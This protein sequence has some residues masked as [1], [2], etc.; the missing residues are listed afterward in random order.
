[1]QE[2][3]PPSDRKSVLRVE[4]ETVGGMASPEAVVE[5]EQRGAVARMQIPAMVDLTEATEGTV[6]FSI[7]M[8]KGICLPMEVLDS[9]ALQEH[10]ANRLEPYTLEE[11]EDTGI[12]VMI[13]V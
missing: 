11:A 8:E 5:G 3:L 12:K 4:V 13:P 1:M 7:E 10:L 9:T 6:M 2:G